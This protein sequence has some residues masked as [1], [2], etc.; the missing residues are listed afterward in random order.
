ME[1]IVLAVILFVGAVIAVDAVRQRR[2]RAART[3]DLRGTLAARLAAPGAALVPGAVASALVREQTTPVDVYGVLGDMLEIAGLRPR[4]QDGAEVKFF[5]LRWGNDYAMLARADREM[6]YRLEVW[7]A[8]LLALMDGTRTVGELVVDRMETGGGLD[9]EPVTDL[10]MALQAGGFLDPPPIPTDELIADRLD[11]SSPGRKKLKRFGKTLTIDWKGADRFVRS[12]YRYLMRPFFWWPVAVVSGLVALAGLIAFFEV[13]AS[14]DFSL[15]GRSAPAESLVLLVLAFFLTFMHELGHAVVI[16]RYDRKVKSAGFMIYFG[17]PAFFVEATDSLML[18]RKQRILQSSAG[19]FTEMIIAGLAALAVF[20]FP[21]GPAANLLYKFA[22]LNYLVIFLNLIPLLELDGYWI[23]SDMIQVPD[24]RP[25]S[26][27]FIQHDLWHKARTREKLTPQEWG[28]GAYGIAGIAFTIFSFWTAWYFWKEI[29]GELIASLWQGG[30]GSKIM[31]IL[32]GAFLAGP[33]VRGLLNLARATWR[34]LRALMRATR[35][36][37]ETSWRVEAAELIDALPAFDDLPEEVLSDLAGRI[38]LRILHPGEPIFRQGDRPDAFYLV[39]RGTV[40]IEDEDPE[41]GDTRILRTM[42]RGESF[43]EMGLLGAHR[44]Q[45]T[46]R[47]VGE[48]ELFEIDKSTFDRLLA[49]DMRAPDFG[50][51]MQAL[52]ELRELPVFHGLDSEQLNDL[53]EHGGWITAT[54]GDELVTQGA[55]G[56]RFFAIASGRADVIRDGDVV[57]Q[58]AKGMYFGEVALL[59]DVP[60]TATVVART[61]MR[62]FAIDREGFELVV[63]DAFQRGTLRPAADRVWQH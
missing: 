19:P 12:S 38:Q 53:L 57:G 29:F 46:V 25:R 61:P 48:V 33:V 5:R 44:R 36:R 2:V 45:A 15:G 27:E 4:L 9:A 31:L 28:L 52:F 34:R 54:P 24:L 63:A 32:L 62:L 13:E 41:T 56:D 22:A 30:P 17:A 47:A 51:T 39:R 58:V 11:P 50:H 14:G 40:Q 18:D 20:A 35:F 59:R 8:E 21:E 26:L 6:H 1:W 3:I 7:E 49:E 43:G 42:T 10:V 37:L 23:L 16:S 55:A 60:R